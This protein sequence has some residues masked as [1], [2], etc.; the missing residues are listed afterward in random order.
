MISEMQ[1]D[2]IMQLIAHTAEIDKRAVEPTA[3]ATQAF[4]QAV[5]DAMHGTVWVTGC[6]SW[7]LDKNGNPTLW[8]WTFERFQEEMKE[9]DYADFAFV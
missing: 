3:D 7:Y 9:P 4:N 6:Q 8:P 5:K 2:Y 1:F